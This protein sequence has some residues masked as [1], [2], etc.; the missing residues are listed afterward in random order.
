MPFISTHPNP[1]GNGD[2]QSRPHITR[3]LRNQLGSSPP[4]SHGHTTATIG[5]TT[6]NSNSLQVEE[7][8]SPFPLALTSL[9]TP[10][11]TGT[12]ATGRKKGKGGAAQAQSS[13]TLGKAV[14]QLTSMR[15]GEIESD[16]GEIRRGAKRKRAQMK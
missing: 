11:I 14:L 3:K 7:I 2:S 9:P 15:D 16:L 12:G 4:P 6:A 5:I 10:G 1:D 8:P 13:Q